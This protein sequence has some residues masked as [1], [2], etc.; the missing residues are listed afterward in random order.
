MLSCQSCK[1]QSWENVAKYL[2]EDIPFLLKS[3]IMKDVEE[4]ISVVCMSLPSNFR[5]FIKWVAE[6]RRTEDNGESLSKEEI[7]RLMLKV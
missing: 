5:D 2:I 1:H 3:T 7:R 4:A 6:L